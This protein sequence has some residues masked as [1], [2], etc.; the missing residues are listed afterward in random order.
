MAAK[1]KMTRVI[2][3]TELSR[4]T[5]NESAGSWSWSLAGWACKLECGHTV[6]RKVSGRS[7][8]PDKCFC[9]E[10]ADVAE[11]AP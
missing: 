11:A 2:S 7:A 3:T 10:C 6:K 9:Q 1:K 5:S 8:P 4:T